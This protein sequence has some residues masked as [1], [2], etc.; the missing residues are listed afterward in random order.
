MSESD[1][2]S[3]LQV[4]LNSPIEEVVAHAEVIN[5]QLK[6][7]E[8]LGGLGQGGKDLYEEVKAVS[9]MSTTRAYTISH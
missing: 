2:H 8:D 3:A 5:E 9:I 7:I 1:L 6:T 4:S